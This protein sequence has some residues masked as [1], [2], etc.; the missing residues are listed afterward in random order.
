MDEPKDQNR[1]QPW[2]MRLYGPAE[3]RWSEPR[4]RPLP[5]PPA[6]AVRANKDKRELHLPADEILRV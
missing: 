5:L 2:H 3:A 4:R 1:I 6:A